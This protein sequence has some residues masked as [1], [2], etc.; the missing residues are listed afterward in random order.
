MHRTL[1]ILVL[2]YVLLHG[3]TYQKDDQLYVQTDSIVHATAETMPVISAKDDD[4]ADDPAIWVNRQ[5]PAN[6]LIIGTNKKA[7]LYLYNLE[8]EELMFYPVGR[9]NNVDVRYDFKLK[10]G[11]LVDLVGGSNRTDNSLIIKAIDPLTYALSDILE[12]GIHSSVDE[13][14]GFAFYHSVKLDRYF[15][16]VGGKDGSTEQWELIPTGNNRIDLKMVRKFSFESQTEGLVADDELGFLYAAEEDRCIWKIPAEP[17][18]VAQRTRI[19]MS[20]SMNPKIE[21]DLEGL[22]IYYGEKGKGY[23]IASV[24]GNSTYAIFDRGG[25]NNYLGSFSI[26]AGAIDGVE[27]T[28]GLDVCSLPLGASYPHGIFVVQDGFNYDDM[29]LSAQNFKIVPWDKIAALFKPHLIFR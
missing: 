25:N 18:E 17:D 8:G 10:N 9:I 6:S 7:G 21:Y 19:A 29:S 5:Y 26:D 16:F 24:Q 11:N 13:V 28:D 1:T 22:T 15:A 23:L 3:C 14:Y 27:E 20:D 12:S 4:A 2:P